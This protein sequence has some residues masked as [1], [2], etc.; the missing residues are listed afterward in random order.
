MILHPEAEGGYS[1]EV[2]DISGG[3]WTQGETVAE[4]IAM[5]EDLIRTVLLGATRYPVATPVDEV[6]SGDGDLVVMGKVDVGTLR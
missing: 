3:S 1:V 6:E 5:G 4:A 2:P